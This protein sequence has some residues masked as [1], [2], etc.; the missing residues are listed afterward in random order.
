MNTVIFFSITVYIDHNALFYISKKE[1]ILQ[2]GLLEHFL[3]F[4]LSLIR[5]IIIQGLTMMN[6]ASKLFFL[7]QKMS[8]LRFFFLS[9]LKY[10]RNELQKRKTKL[11]FLRK[12]SILFILL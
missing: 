1:S 8:A 3:F 10:R 6:V 4:L 5:R 2:A 12:L 7:F 9:L 11:L